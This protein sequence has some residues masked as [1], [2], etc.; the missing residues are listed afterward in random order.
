MIIGGGT[1]HKP[2]ERKCSALG[3]AYCWVGL[4]LQAPALI[5]K[6][7]SDRWKVVTS[8]NWVLVLLIWQ[9]TLILIFLCYY[10]RQLPFNC[11]AFCYNVFVIICFGL[12]RLRGD[13]RPRA[14]CRHSNYTCFTKDEKL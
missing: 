13:D 5:I 12:F 1:F 7:L 2:G 9:Y 6:V 11:F 3:L 8:C 4:L 10:N 14:L